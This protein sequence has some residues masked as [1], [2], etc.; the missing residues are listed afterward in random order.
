MPPE[1]VDSI[2][3]TGVQLCARFTD[4]T[5]VLEQFY[6]P[7]RLEL[8]EARL[9]AVENFRVKVRLGKGDAAGVGNWKPRK[10]QPGEG[11][12]RC[13]QHDCHLS[14]LTF[15]II[16]DPYREKKVIRGPEDTSSI[17]ISRSSFLN[18]GCENVCASL[19]HPSLREWEG[20]IP[21][22]G[23]FSLK[24]YDVVAL[25]EVCLCA[26]VLI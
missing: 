12:D 7:R 19:A 2:S 17:L 20:F 13:S 18:Q 1:V 25:C 26:P 5:F 11:D 21:F 8:N 15:G 10:G 23:L 3:S 14:M 4:L 9:A 6:L 22:L 16:C 24:A